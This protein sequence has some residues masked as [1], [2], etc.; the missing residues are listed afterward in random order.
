VRVPRDNRVRHVSHQLELLVLADPPMQ[1]VIVLHPVVHLA[2]VLQTRIEWLQVRVM[3][4][5]AL[6]EPVVV[7]AGGDSMD[8]AVDVFPVVNTGGLSSG[9]GGDGN[10]EVVPDALERGARVF[11]ANR[12]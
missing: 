7:A 10:E 12:R 2:N 11:Q 6:D 9:F 4:E 8:E 5:Q 3:L 1:P